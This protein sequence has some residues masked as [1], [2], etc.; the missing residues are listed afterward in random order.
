MSESSNHFYRNR[1]QF[2]DWQAVVIYSSRSMEQKN[3]YPYRALLNSDQ[4]HRIYLDELGDI[5]ELPLGLALMRLTIETSKNAPEAARYL[6]AR[7][8]NEIRDPQA[9][10]A[11][12]AMLTTIMVYRFDKLSRSEVEEM[13]GTSLEKTRVYQEAKAEGQIIGEARGEIIGEARGEVR[14]QRSLLQVQLDRK[15]GKLP[16]RTKK[17]IASLELVKLEALAIALL[18]LATI[19]DLVSWLKDS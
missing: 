6:L 10:R 4:L 15:F 16:S 8:N 7:S 9:N 5:R 17:S 2:T 13:L 3:I 14:G 11:I 12:I 1:D 19:D 18:D